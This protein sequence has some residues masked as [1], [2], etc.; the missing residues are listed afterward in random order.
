MSTRGARRRWSRKSSQGELTMS[1]GAIAAVLFSVFALGELHAAEQTSNPVH[2]GYFTPSNP[3]AQRELLPRRSGNS[4][5]HL[6]S[7]ALPDI[8]VIAQPASLPC[9]HISY[10]GTAFMRGCE[11]NRDCLAH[12]VPIAP[13]LYSAAIE[14]LRKQWVPKKRTMAKDRVD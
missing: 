12:Y 11:G 4:K 9:P 2:P 1:A 7:A 3:P 14:C 13:A 6:P 8:V 5:Q 10:C